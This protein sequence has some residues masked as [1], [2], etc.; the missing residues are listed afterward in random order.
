MWGFL[1][2]LDAGRRFASIVPCGIPRRFLAW[3]EVLSRCTLGVG[4][5]ASCRIASFLVA[6]LVSCSQKWS[7]ESASRRYAS[8]RSS[9][10]QRRLVAYQAQVCSDG[11]LSR[12]RDTQRRFASV[13]SCGFTVVMNRASAL[14]RRARHRFASALSC[15]FTKLMYAICGIFSWRLDARCRFVSTVSYVVSMLLLA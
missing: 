2:L 14:R 7:L 15:A 13:A 3:F 8:R 9:V 5:P 10:F 4:F 1:Q 6:S 12:R 11:T